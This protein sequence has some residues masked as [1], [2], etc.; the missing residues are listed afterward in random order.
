VE[1]VGEILSLVRLRPFDTAT[2]AGRSNERY[3]RA[4]LTAIAAVAA[5]LVAVVVMLV[6]VP[7]TLDYLGSERYGMWMTIGSIT[8]MLGFADFGIGNG[9]LNVVADANGRDDRHLG[10]EAV[11]SGFFLLSLIGVGLLVLFAVISTFVPWA[12]L[13]NVSAPMA[14]SEAA[15]AT[16][17]FFVVWVLN[18]PLGIVQRAQLGYQRG[19]VNYAWQAA[20]S[21]LS[22]A[23]AILAVEV[24]AGLP[25]LVVALTGGPLLAVALNSL[26]EFGWASP[27]LRPAW[28]FVSRSAARLILRLGLWFFVIQLAMTLGYASTNLVIAQVLGSS[29]VTQY[30]VPARLFAFIGV[31][32][33]LLMMPLWPAYGEAMTR[34]DATWVRRTL[35]RTLLV[36]LVLTVIPAVVL[37]VWGKQII[38]LWV[39]DAVTPSFWLLGGLGVWTVLSGLGATIA[40]F[41]NGASILRFQAVCAMLMAVSALLLEVLFSRTWGVEAVPWALVLA[42]TV[43][44]VIPL[45]I[46]VPMLLRRMAAASQGL[47]QAGGSHGG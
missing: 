38:G 16:T 34:G 7:L 28:S 33:G 4:G 26:V 31:V 36:T 5:K 27:W 46:Y 43:F 32:V 9:V 45:I 18:V 35:I 19:F 47:P 41:L 2:V 39:G 21:C 44:S 6:T 15:P 23:G 11:S 20:G 22:L 17:V 29:E 1:R 25:W 12:R 24:G 37:V 10:R 42:Y 8:L 3:R 30:A 13:Y 14:M 40:I